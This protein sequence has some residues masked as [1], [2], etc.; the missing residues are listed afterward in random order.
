MGFPSG[1]SGKEPACQC[2]RCKRRGFNPWVGK[3]PWRREPT[4]IF[5]SGETMDRG[6]WRAMVHRVAKS[7]TLLKGLS[8]NAYQ[9]P[10]GIQITWARND[11]VGKGGNRVRRG[12]KQTL[13]TYLHGNCLQGTFTRIFLPK[14]PLLTFAARTQ[15]YLHFTDKGTEVH[16]NETTQQSTYQCVL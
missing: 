3:I 13:T 14:D 12:S 5:L 8:T 2:R 11:L 4:P 15:H 6:A 16:S 1:A 10:S 9:S 7:Q